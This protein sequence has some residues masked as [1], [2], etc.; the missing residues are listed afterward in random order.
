MPRF[1]AIKEVIDNFD[2]LTS[3]WKKDPEKLQQLWVKVRQLNGMLCSRGSAGSNESSNKKE[4]CSLEEARAV[5]CIGPEAL[6]VE[7]KSADTPSVTTLYY[8]EN[9]R[10][11]SLVRQFMQAIVASGEPGL[12]DVLGH[13][14]PYCILCGACCNSYDLDITAVDIERIADF[15]GISE[16]E[17]WGRHLEPGERT[18]N[19]RDGRIRRLRKDDS[20][21]DC[22]FLEAKGPVE[23]FCRIYEARPQMCRDYQW[24]NRLCQKKSIALKGHEHMEYILSCH[25]A[26]DMAHLITHQT[27]AG[28]KEPFVIALKCHDGL[29]EKFNIVREEVLQILT[30]KER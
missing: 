22:V 18:W 23:T 26:D 5:I 1:L 12:V 9:A 3:M 30:R 21:G 15:L 27:S 7:L 16:K 29:R 2:S 8:H 24:N 6:A 4:D 20:E 17:L 25:V 11:L 13:P 10:L 19:R 28:K 14:D